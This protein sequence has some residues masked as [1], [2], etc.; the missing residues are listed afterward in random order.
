MCAR[1]SPAFQYTLGQH[2]LIEQLFFAYVYKFTVSHWEGINQ[3]KQ[4]YT[5]LFINA[6]TQ[7]FLTIT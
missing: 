6:G 2:K 5:S 3:E 7:L 4:L 1:E